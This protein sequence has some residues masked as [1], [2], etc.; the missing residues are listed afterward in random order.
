MTPR[1]PDRPSLASLKY[2]AK[3]LV[4]RHHARDVG[5]CPDLRALRQWRH[6]SDDDILQADVVLADAQHA[7]ALRYGFAHWLALR[8]H[9]LA[10][11]PAGIVSEV[12]RKLTQRERAEFQSR[13]I[14]NLPG[15]LPEDILGPARE[16]VHDGL[17]QAQVMRAGSWTAGRLDA[18]A[19][20]VLLATVSKALKACTKRSPE[21]A[22]I[23]TA[24]LHHAAEQVM[25]QRA[26]LTAVN[27]PQLLFTP[28]NAERWQVPHKLWHMDIPRLGAIGCPG[29]QMFTFIDAVAPGSAGTVVVA[30][31]HRYVNDQGKVKSAEVKKRLWQ[32]NAWFQGLLRPD[33]TDRRH[34]LESS[35]QENGVDLQ[36]VE[37]TGAPGDVWL[38]D[39]RLLHSLAPNTSAQ[40]R[41]MA[42][43]RYYLPESLKAAYSG[44]TDDV[45]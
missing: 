6:L 5:V 27:R 10:V 35:M 15:F 8:D 2:Q 9:V 28:P 25:E 17:E 38:M 29:V 11:A 36:V 23:C 1:L 34:Y 18:A 13:G 16:V 40:P 24:E 33:G 31:S 22:G 4:K 42:T 39:L 37:L 19:D 30:G 20:R 7:I 21:F 12:N 43:Q 26:L 32:T 41:L 14:V 3:Q 44:A 45:A